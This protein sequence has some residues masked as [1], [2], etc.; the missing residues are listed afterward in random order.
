MVSCCL[1]IPDGARVA[2]CL[3]ADVCGHT[4]LSTCMGTTIPRSA[5]FDIVSLAP[6]HARTYPMR[7]HVFFGGYIKHGDTPHAWEPGSGSMVA[8]S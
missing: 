2:I 6:E 3:V 5:F 8:P 4:T 7:G 1:V